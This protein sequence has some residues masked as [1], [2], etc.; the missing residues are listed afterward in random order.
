MPLSRS[1][2]ANCAP[3]KTRLV[4]DSTIAR[5]IPGAN[6]PLRWRAISASGGTITSRSKCVWLSIKPGSKVACPRSMVL[7]PSACACTCVG[8]P[9]SLILPFSIRTAAGEST[10]PVLGS[11][12]WPAFTRVTGAGDW[13][14]ICAIENKTKN[15]AANI[16]HSLRMLSPPYHHVVPQRF[17]SI[18]TTDY[19]Y[20]TTVDVDEGKRFFSD[21]TAC[22]RSATQGSRREVAKRAVSRF[23]AD[24]RL[25]RKQ[26][27]V[28]ATVPQTPQ[29]S[30][31]PKTELSTMLAAR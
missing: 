31:A 12:R 4:G 10:F 15:N 2:R 19:V 5:S 24:Y 7:T 20:A 13:A 26:Q 3:I 11:S 6:L 29:R 16:V 23:L 17:S 8:E 25:A 21:L 27:A 9:T 18:S 1:S 30:T 14:T 28:C 22:D